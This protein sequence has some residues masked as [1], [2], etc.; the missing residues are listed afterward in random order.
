[1]GEFN[2][3]AAGFPE[4]A[5]VAHLHA[6]MQRQ[7]PAAALLFQSLTEHRISAQPEEKVFFV[8]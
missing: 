5:E 1:M 3:Q 8:L 2:S 7:L 4:A 6:H